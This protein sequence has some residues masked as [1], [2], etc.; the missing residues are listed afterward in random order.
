M[1]PRLKAV[2]AREDYIL[3]LLFDNGELRLFDVSPY[4]E[5]GFFQELKQVGYFAS[6]GLF[7]GSVQWPHG[8][9]FCPDT[10]YL[11]GQH[12]ELPPAELTQWVKEQMAITSA[13]PN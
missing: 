3:W 10:L 6:V 2:K 13:E 9:D 11:E 5:K 7:L 8:Q 1:N 12:I 4:L